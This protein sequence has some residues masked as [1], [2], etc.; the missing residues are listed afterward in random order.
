VQVS[1]WPVFIPFDLT[2]LM[3]KPKVTVFKDEMLDTILKIG[4]IKVN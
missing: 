2:T 1:G 3:E 4:D